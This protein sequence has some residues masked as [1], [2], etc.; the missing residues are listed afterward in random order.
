LL[1]EVDYKA[2]ARFFLPATYKLYPNLKKL[3]FFLEKIIEDSRSQQNPVPMIAFLP[4]L[5]N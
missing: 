4:K 5:C 2:T 3:Q 1:V